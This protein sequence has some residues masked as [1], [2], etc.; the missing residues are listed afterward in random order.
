MATQQRNGRW[1][2]GGGRRAADGRRT[3]GAGDGQRTA[4]GRRRTANGRR[5]TSGQRA[6]ILRLQAVAVRPH[7]RYISSDRRPSPPADLGQPATA[8]GWR[9]MAEERGGAAYRIRVAK[10][11]HTGTHQSLRYGERLAGD[12]RNG[13]GSTDILHFY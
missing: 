3:A 6:V 2:V 5:R 4:D 9:K 10:M 11:G 13:R 8:A 12:W 7:V 1:A